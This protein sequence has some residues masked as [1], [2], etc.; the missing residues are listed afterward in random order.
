VVNIS[1]CAVREVNCRDVEIISVILPKYLLLLDMTGLLFYLEDE[2]EEFEIRETT[3]DRW[4]VTD[5]QEH[6]YAAAVDDYCAQQKCY[7]ESSRLFDSIA[8][9]ESLLD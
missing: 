6:S 4:S 8:R 9:Y 3:N 7:E 2:R 5:D 1:L